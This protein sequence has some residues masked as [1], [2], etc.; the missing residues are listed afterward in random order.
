MHVPGKW[1]LEDLLD[2][3]AAVLQQHGLSRRGHGD[4]F[5]STDWVDWTVL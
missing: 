3:A 5:Q 1:A 2:L 4:R